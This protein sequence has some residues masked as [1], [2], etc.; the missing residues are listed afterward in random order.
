VRGDERVRWCVAAHRAL[1]SLVGDGAPAAL[2]GVY[3]P[4]V[5]R[6]ANRVGLQILDDTVGFA[7][8]AHTPATL[9]LL[10]PRGIAG[11]DLAVVGAAFQRLKTVTRAGHS[12]AVVERPVLV[13]AEQLWPAAPS[14]HRRL[15][16]TATAFVPDTRP[17]RRG[18]WSL[19]DATA[20]SVGL[21][22]R[23]MLSGA[24]RGEAFYRQVAADAAARGVQA[25]T[26]TRVSDGDQTRFVH[27]VNPG[28]VVV[29][30]RARLSLGTL[31]GDRAVVAIGQSRHLGGGLL[32]PVD[33]PLDVTP[34]VGTAA[35][36]AVRG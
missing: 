6:P 19:A 5:P 9:A 12:R 7:G 10:V 29:P 17:P 13:P 16:R 23:D 3:P 21:V 14:G 15:W 34:V 25:F 28:H 24:G 35:G 26:V 4:G 8:M 20:L 32:L 36:S 22:W 27:R 2:T 1:I 30:L 18:T 11:S 31:A 33:E